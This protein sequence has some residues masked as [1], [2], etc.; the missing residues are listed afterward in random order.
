MLVAEKL[1]AASP[2]GWRRPWVQPMANRPRSGAGLF[3]A[4]IIGCERIGVEPTRRDACAGIRDLVFYSSLQ[5]TGDARPATCGPKRAHNLQSWPFLRFKAAQRGG[6]SRTAQPKAPRDRPI[7]LRQSGQSQSRQYRQYEART[8]PPSLHTNPVYPPPPTAVRTRSAL[9]SQE[10][11]VADGRN[12]L[13][14]WRLSQRLPGSCWSS[15]TSCL[16][17][18]RGEMRSSGWRR[19]R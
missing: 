17:R 18:S 2:A 5:R 3:L 16:G 14:F 8:A 1:Q 9:R 7:P 4:R 13:A 11:S 6:Q 12:P 10:R 15:E 19:R